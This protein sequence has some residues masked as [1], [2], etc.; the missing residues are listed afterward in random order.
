[1]DIVYTEPNELDPKLTIEQ[2]FEGRFL[3]VKIPLDSGPSDIA[4]EHVGGN[5]PRK[6]NV[7]KNGVGIPEWPVPITVLYY[8]A[9]PG[10]RTVIVNG[11]AY[12]KC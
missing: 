4:V 6:P 2:A 1:M 8:E 10:C 5:R 7:P 3:V 12:E 11:V 9:S